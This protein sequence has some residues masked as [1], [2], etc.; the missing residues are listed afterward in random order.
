LKERRERR[1][2]MGI[3]GRVANRIHRKKEK[4]NLEIKKKVRS[5]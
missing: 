4:K 2:K 5:Y 1:K 3:E